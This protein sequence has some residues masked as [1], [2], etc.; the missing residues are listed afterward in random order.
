MRKFKLSVYQY[1]QALVKQFGYADPE[2]VQRYAD[3]RRAHRAGFNRFTND[4]NCKSCGKGKGN[5][6]DKR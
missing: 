3:D 5:D 1:E 2:M 6:S 4:P